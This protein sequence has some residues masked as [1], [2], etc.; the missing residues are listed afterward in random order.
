MTAETLEAKQTVTQSVPKSSRLLS[1][2]ALR[3]F[4]NALDFGR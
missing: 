3:G 2:D 4:D 1:L